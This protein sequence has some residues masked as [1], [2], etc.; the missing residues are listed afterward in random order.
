MELNLQGVGGRNILYVI[1]KRNNSRGQFPNQE[2]GFIN[3]DLL[4]IATRFVPIVAAP[5]LQ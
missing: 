5:R 4:I 2:A 3:Q 1:P